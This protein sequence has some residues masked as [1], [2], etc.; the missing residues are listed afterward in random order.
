MAALA[1]K[2]SVQ[3]KKVCPS[4]LLGGVPLSVMNH[5]PKRILLVSFF[6]LMAALFALLAFIGPLLAGFTLETTTTFTFFSILSVGSFLLSLYTL[7]YDA[8]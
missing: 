1:K 7:T 6:I 5:P 4:R 8:P 2:S 3:T